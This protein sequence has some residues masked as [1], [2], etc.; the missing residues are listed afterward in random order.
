MDIKRCPKCGKVKDCN[1]FYKE[2]SR[3]D[4]RRGICIVCDNINKGKWKQANKDKVSGY[5]RISYKRRLINCPEKLKARRMVADALKLGKLE[6]Q[7]C[8][9]GKTKVQGHH[10]DYSKPL[11]VKWLC[12]KCHNKL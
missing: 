3:K 12:T 6:R 9:C 10:D 4:G 7:P 2:K 1:R 11:D 8:P 5:N